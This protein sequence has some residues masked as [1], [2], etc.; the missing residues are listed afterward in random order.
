MAAVYLGFLSERRQVAA[1]AGFRR[2]RTGVL[3]LRLLFLGLL[4]GGHGG[5]D[6]SPGVGGDAAV[7]HQSLVIL[8]DGRWNGQKDG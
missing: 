3:P 2:L 6:V 7:L 4:L 1:A 5:D 8:G